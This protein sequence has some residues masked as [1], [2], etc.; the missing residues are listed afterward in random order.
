MDLNYSEYANK[1]KKMK[2]V[3]RGREREHLVFFSRRK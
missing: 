1:N 2:I 3:S